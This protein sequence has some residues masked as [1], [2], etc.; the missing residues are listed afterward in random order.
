MTPAKGGAELGQQ[1]VLLRSQGTSI[2]ALAR[3]FGI[4]RNTVRSILREHE[5]RREQ[6]HDVLSAAPKRR[7]ASKLDPFRPLI[8]EILTMYPRITGTRLHEK[9]REEA[10]YTGGTTIVRQLL[11]ELRPAPKRDLVVRFETE[12][13][14]QGQ[15]D[16]SSYTIPFRRTGKS[17][18]LCFSY[19]LGY[20]RRHF[21]DFTTNRDFYTLIRRHQDAFSHFRGVPRECL[22]DNEKT[23]VLRWEAGRPVFNPAFTAFITHYHCRPIACRPRHPETKGKIEAPF[24]YIESN[25]LAGREFR[26]LEDLRDLAC[27]WL[28]EK[29]DKHVHA[30]T[31]QTPLELFAEEQEHLLPLPP[32]RYDTSEVALR[33]CRADGLVEFETNGYS[34]PPG[35]VADILTVKA[36]EHEIFIYNPE[37]DL[38]ACHERAQRGLGLLI[39]NPE[40]RQPKKSRG[41][42]LESVREGFLALGNAA[43]EFLTGLTRRYPK[44]CGS[45]ARQIL[46]LKASYRTDDINEAMRHASSYK[47]FEA[48]AVERILEVR[49]SRRTLES[50]RNERASQALERTL[51]TIRQRALEEYGDLFT[52]REEKENT[53]EAAGSDLRADQE[54]PGSSEPD[55]DREDP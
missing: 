34:V 45:H 31:R 37:I 36:T 22:Y 55:G 47:A 7:R 38:I 15:M 17:T 13:G 33:V 46:L 53:D 20:S 3:R 23:V 1:I 32:Q 18:A 8:A 10:G 52:R 12:P 50:I 21:I 35:N 19:I 24:R 42:G 41:G 2:R 25:L 11:A 43:E 54:A 14:R 40:H 16:W 51:P 44:H 28:T 27:W 48:G 26:D 30:T 49:F 5:A 29:S 39:V 6:G 4:A 9:L